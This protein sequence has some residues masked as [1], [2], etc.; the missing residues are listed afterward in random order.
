MMRSPAGRSAGLSVRG[1][2]EVDCAA[3]SAAPPRRRRHPRR[4]HGG[5]GARPGRRD[6]GVNK[7][8]WT[9]TRLDP[10]AWQ[11]PARHGRRPDGEARP[12]A[13]GDEA[14]AGGAGRGAHTRS[15]P[16]AT[17][18]R[19][20]LTASS[21]CITCASRPTRWRPRQS[22]REMLQDLLVAAV[23]NAMEHSQTLAAE[24]LQRPVAR[25]GLARSVSC[26]RR[27][28]LTAPPTPRLE[29]RPCMATLATPKPFNG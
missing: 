19:W 7:C 5:H 18:C 25:P 15:R 28:S 1:Q 2:V 23:N 17:R 26:R 8:R 11:P 9:M 3:S 16:A 14:R 20:S 21:G 12:D 29:D 22:D 13:G 6:R 10:K 27:H 4:R 24:R